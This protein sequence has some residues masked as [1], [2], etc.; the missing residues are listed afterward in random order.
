MSLLKRKPF[1]Q[2]IAFCLVGS[3]GFLVD[4]GI[5]SLLVR[6]FQVTPV[7]ARFFSFPCAVLVTWYLNR[8]VTFSGYASTRVVQ[9]WFRYLLVST[10]G[11]LLNFI[12]YLLCITL[13]GFMYAF[14]E[15]ALVIASLVAMVFNFNGARHYAF[16]DHGGYAGK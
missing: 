15:T 1:S 14:P 16:R 3:V 5:L 9:E 4:A 8:T 6:G 2:Y 10:A 12:V 7:V 11:N 13:S